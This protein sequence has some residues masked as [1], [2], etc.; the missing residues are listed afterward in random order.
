MLIYILSMERYGDREGHHYNCGAF[1]DL[2]VATIE[3]LEHERW[4]ADKY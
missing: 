1:T 3:G 2:A 4:R